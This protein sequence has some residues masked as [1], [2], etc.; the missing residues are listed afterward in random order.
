MC[1]ISGKEE[2]RLVSGVFK[3]N[4]YSGVYQDLKPSDLPVDMNLFDIAGD[5]YP[6][7][8]EILDEGYVLTAT[9]NTGDCLYVPAF[10]YS[11]SRTLSEQTTMLHFTY[12]PSSILSDLL[13]LKHLPL[14]QMLYK[15]IY[16]KRT[17]VDS[18]STLLLRENGPTL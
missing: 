18:I 17:T 7:T 4:L 6:L 2:F 15:N 16:N 12:P 14:F 8:K 1:V 10:Y 9:L 11:Q 5:M 13:F 3:Q